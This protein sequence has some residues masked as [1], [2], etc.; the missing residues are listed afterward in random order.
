MVS[1]M[2]NY[3][4]YVDVFVNTFEVDPKEV[5]KLEYQGIDNWDSVGH[6]GLIAGLEDAFD[7]MME[8]DDIIDL[9]SFKKGKEILE[10]KYGIIF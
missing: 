8:T 7:I 9:N 5:E 1:L 4:K 3:Q 2:S 10:S 6:M